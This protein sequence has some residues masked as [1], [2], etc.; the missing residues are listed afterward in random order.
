MLVTH[1]IC[2]VVEAA[3]LQSPYSCRL[4]V[5]RKL[6]TMIVGELRVV[7]KTR[8]AKKNDPN[9]GLITYMYKKLKLTQL[10]TLAARA[11]QSINYCIGDNDYYMYMYVNNIEHNRD[12]R[13]FVGYTCMK[14]ARSV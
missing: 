8:A 9:K 12:Y 14:T 11:I 13:A 7:F 6:I 5:V 2:T 4:A 1:C 3:F 10:N